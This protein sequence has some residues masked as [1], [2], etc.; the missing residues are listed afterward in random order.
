MCVVNTV[1]ARAVTRRALAIIG[2]AGPD[3]IEVEVRDQGD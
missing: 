1:G 2:G 3:N